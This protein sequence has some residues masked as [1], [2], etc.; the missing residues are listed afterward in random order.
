MTI[1]NKL[2][3]QILVQLP[4]SLP[5]P[6]ILQGRNFAINDL[7]KLMMECKEDGDLKY[8]MF[9]VTTFR[10]ICFACARVLSF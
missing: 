9:S 5:V 6:L 7:R 1:S 3:C 4:F 8:G 10:V 2:H